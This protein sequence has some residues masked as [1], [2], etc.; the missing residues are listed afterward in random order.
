MAAQQ[1]VLFIVVLRCCQ[2]YEMHLGLYIHKVQ[3]I[4]VWL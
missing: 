2:Q 3:N 1:Y 4:L